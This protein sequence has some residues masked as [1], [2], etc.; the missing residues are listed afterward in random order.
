MTFREALN[1]FN[2]Y[3]NEFNERRTPDRLN[4]VVESGG[5]GNIKEW[6]RRH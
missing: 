3:V 2:Q 4:C 5:V 6:I 1:K